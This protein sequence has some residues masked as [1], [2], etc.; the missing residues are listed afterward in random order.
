ME[1]GPDGIRVNA[2]SPGLILS[3]R[4]RQ[5]NEQR[6][7]GMA[8]DV[9]KLPLRRLGE[10]EDCANALE[11]LATDL[12]SYVTGQCISVCGGSALQPA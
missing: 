9:E 4:I 7:L 6:G 12:S 3:A 10:P 8:A 2:I 11:F 1:L 5:T